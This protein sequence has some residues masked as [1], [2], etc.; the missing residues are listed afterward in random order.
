M[1]KKKLENMAVV[2]VFVR[3][4]EDREHQ[5]RERVKSRRHVRELR[6]PARASQALVRELWRSG[7]RK[8]RKGIGCRK[9]QK[10]RRQA[11]RTY[12]S[13]LSGRLAGEW[14]RRRL[15]DSSARRL[16]EAWRQFKIK[17]A[18]KVEIAA[19]KLSRKSK[20]KASMMAGVGA[21]PRHTGCFCVLWSG[22]WFAP[23]DNAEN[24]NLAAV[25]RPRLKGKDRQ[26]RQAKAGL[27]TAVLE[28]VPECAS[29]A[30][31]VVLAEDGSPVEHRKKRKK[32]FKKKTKKGR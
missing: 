26:P 31:G 17:K 20:A 32:K 8:R 10:I 2:T 16:G 11:R 15:R 30:K 24:N 22:E 29:P 14:R 5:N 4:E 12:N 18:K 6:L 9:R 13:T 3:I 21:C 1:E 7:N 28:D 23:P 25:D 27:K 19:E